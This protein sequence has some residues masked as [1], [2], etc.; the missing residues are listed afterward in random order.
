MKICSIRI[1][2]FQQFRDTYIDFTDPATGKPADKICIIGKN[3]TG[4]STLLNL[5]VTSLKT[6]INNLTDVTFYGSSYFSVELEVN[7]NQVFYFF[8]RKSSYILNKQ[9]QT[10]YPN[11]FDILVQYL[12]TGRGFYAL[13]INYIAGN[14]DVSLMQLNDNSTDLLIH[15]TA[16]S[17]TNNQLTITDVPA[18]D[19]NQALALF[20]SFPYYHIINNDTVADFWK[21][22]IYLIK[23]RENEREEY[24]NRP[25]NLDKTKSQLIKEFEEIN[26]K[27]LNKI[28]DQWNRILGK[29][30]LEFDVEQA[31]N[32]IQ[33]NE[34][35][36]AYVTLR[37]TKERIEYNNLSTGIRNFIFRIGHIYSLYFNRE[38]KGG[39]V[40][41][42]EPENSLFPDFLYDLVE[43]YKKALTDKNGEN[44]SQLFMST[45]SPIIA[46]QFEPHER[47]ILD[48]DEDGYVVATKGEA[49][50]GDDPNDI[51]L[52]DFNLTH[53]MGKK[54]QDFWNKYVTLKK[55]L[56]RTD[57]E[58]EKEKL[59][60][61]I[62][63]IG[64]KYNFS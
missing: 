37:K 4:K 1:K 62:L 41:I 24:E 45:H 63:E 47:V 42:D 39:F 9:I 57:N 18:T 13:F 29:A 51:L 44:N 43:V 16:E 22:L 26:P 36:Q 40:M 19:L 14:R 5:M 54:G 64:T 10:D 38:V 50:I 11:W 46:A 8:S 23:K 20:H 15:A 59:V 31:K 52:K 56:R 6:K 49:P 2:G 53:V 61:E 21:I 60:K 25:E 58:P 7:A 48:W 34:N 32:P 30:G 33:L 35:L 12:E 27:I 3:G 55:Q 28:A 17:V